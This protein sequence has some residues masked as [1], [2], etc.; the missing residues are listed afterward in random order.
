MWGGWGCVV[1]IK[2]GKKGRQ[3]G[4]G[5]KKVGVGKGAGGKVV[6]HRMCGV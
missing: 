2:R 3:E 5:V 4:G 6:R 1:G